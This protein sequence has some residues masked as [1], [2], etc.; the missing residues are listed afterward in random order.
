MPLLDLLKFSRALADRRNKA[1]LL[2][3][4]DLREQH[5]V[6]AQLAGALSTP[7]LDV[8]ERFHSN[9]QLVDQIAGFSPAD[10]FK[11]VATQKS[12]PLLIISGLEFLLAAWL[13]QGD[14]K[15]VKQNF[16]QQI[17]L[18]SQKPAFLLV[19]QHDPVFAAYA[20]T[21][22]SGQLII[23]LSQTLALA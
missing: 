21:R 10:F 15:Q 17:E 8:L 5:A 18:W 4:P 23:E 1:A 19:T 13:A 12:S 11:L 3:T 22:H 14:A 7:H 16:C 6:A 2:L 20:P 9:T